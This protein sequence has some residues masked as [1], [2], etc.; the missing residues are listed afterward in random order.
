MKRIFGRFGAKQMGP[1][2]KVSTGVSG[3]DNILHGG[4]MPNRVY[5][6]EGA[7]GTGKTTLGL[8]FLLDQCAEEEDGNARVYVTLSQSAAELRTIA[9]SHG[10][11]ISGIKIVE[12]LAAEVKDRS[13]SQ[14]VL[15]TSE[16]ELNDLIDKIE[17]IASSNNPC[18]LVIDSLSE[19]RLMSG[20][21]LR[22]RRA[23]LGLAIKLG[24]MCATTML[25]Q[26]L[27]TTQTS[28]SNE[29]S[30]HGTIRLDWK[31]PDFGVVQR[32]LQVLKMRGM[33]FFEGYHD[34]AIQEGGLEIFPRL[35][36]ESNP[37]R[38]VEGWEL[39]SDD[40]TLDALIGGSLPGNGTTLISGDT[41]AG[42][43]VL[44][45]KFAHA[46]VKR[47]IKT[48]IYLFE[49]M[50]DDFLERS[51]R[52]GMDLSDPE[53]RDLVSVEHF[54]PVETSQGQLFATIRDQ[55]RNGT[56]LVILDSLTGFVRTL[57]AGGDI[58]PQFNAL[59]NSLK[60]LKV[61]TLMTLNASES[62]QA[63]Q[64]EV[65]FSFLTDNVI[66]V[67]YFRQGGKVGRSIWMAEKRY[68]PHSREV[69]SLD[70][71]PEG[72]RAAEIEG[73]FNVTR[74]TTNEQQSDSF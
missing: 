48:S 23:V 51:K 36:P 42:K 28:N 12:L 6:V 55:V 29:L 33:P 3:L 63:G 64:D 59:L 16:E 65:D 9:D 49:E 43:S 4:L 8:Q 61:A 45:T 40:E 50:T 32:R 14:T 17:E 66:R 20:S 37:D 73:S 72:V 22:F 62:H 15:T 56:R 35:V 71:G 1:G 34:M 58:L 52:L 53:V 67:A 47:G 11:D 18:R 69:R 44:S 24:D 68:G 39:R 27:E 7:A 10:F 60:Q 5:L 57:R 25:I 13:I 31:A 70:I 54:N 21:V 30:T 2:H 19:L 46:T 74:Q 38:E 26:G 41:G